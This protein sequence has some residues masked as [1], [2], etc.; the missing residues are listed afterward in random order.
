MR[1]IVPKPSYSVLPKTGQTTS[2][3]TYDDGYYQMGNPITPR[4]TDNGLTITDNATGLMWEQKTNDG[5]V[6]DMNNTYTWFD[7]FD[8]FLYGPPGLNNTNFAGHNDWRIPNVN[9]LQSIY[10]QDEWP[11]PFIY[12]IFTGQPSSVEYGPKYWS[13]TTWPVDT[14]QALYVCFGISGDSQAYWPKDSISG[15]LPATRYFVRA[16]RGGSGGLH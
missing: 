2:Y 8:A 6:H 10:Q 13:S 4:F 12:P 9:E 3:Q 16:V 11:P 14:T 15:D 7:A 1:A 5:S